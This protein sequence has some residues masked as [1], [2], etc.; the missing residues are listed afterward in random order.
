MS[1]SESTPLLSMKDD[2]DLEMGESSKDIAYGSFSSME[3]GLDKAGILVDA[4]TEVPQGRHLGIFSTMVL[5]V[6]R[7][8]GSGI[9]ATPSSI[10]VNCGGNTLI[11]FGVWLLA[12]VLSFAGL[13]LFLEFGSWLPRSGGRKNFLEQTYTKPKLMMSV[14]FACYTVLTGFTMSNAIVFGKYFLCA[15]GFSSISQDNESN[16]SKYISIAV[17]ITG[18]TIHGTSVKYGVR[19]QNFLGGMKFILIALMCLIG[20]YSLVFYKTPLLSDDAPIIN[21]APIYSFQDEATISISS[22][23]SAFIG[24]FFCFTGWDSVHAVSSEIKNPKR[25][26]KIAGP[27]SLL[28]CFFCYTMMNLAY[29]RTLSYEEIKEAGP[30]V[31]SVL[32][33]KLFGPRFGGELLSL[34]VALSTASNIMV[35]LY[36]ISRMNQEVFREG[37]LPFS[38]PLASNW[39]WSS[40]LPSLLICGGLSVIWLTA[41]P[42]GGA[43]YDYLVSMEGYGNQFFL[44]LVAV[45]IFIYRRKRVDEVPATKAPSIGVIALI[46]VSTYLLVA[47]FVGPQT[48][49]RISIFPPYQVTALSFVGLCF[50]FWLVK[51]FI[52]P[53]VMKYELEPRA[54]ALDDG[55]VVTKWTKKYLD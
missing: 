18:V 8:V 34:S 7:M 39:P 6:S 14:V 4:Y 43:S 42:A 11:Y 25:T 45:G 49:N 54:F 24:A 15:I 22:L 48:Y 37:Y 50:L 27:A 17:V 53:K 44:L 47:P 51:F 26:L 9:F 38:I 31:G 5:F 32:F 19:V 10:F 28:V 23:A 30:L 13:F 29:V 16:V 1:K 40:P 35:V 12:A 41:L 3:L 2:S 20:I 36:G 33:T 46:I 21:R 52:L 55:L